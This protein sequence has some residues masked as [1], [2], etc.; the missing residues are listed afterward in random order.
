[1]KLK[2][3]LHRLKFGVVLIAAVVFSHHSPLAFAQSKLAPVPVNAITLSV[4][5]NPAKVKEKVTLTAQVKTGGKAATGGTVTF[6][7]GKLPLA[8]AQ[9]VGKKPAKGYKT[10][11][12][13][14]TTILAPGSHSLTAVYG[15]T[16]GSPKIVRSKRVALKITGRTAS[17][18]G[19][20]A[21]ANAHHPKN[22]DFTASVHGLGLAS[23][24]GMV[25]VTDITT[26]TDLGMAPLDAK[27]VSHSFAKARVIDA[28]GMPVQSV[29]AD[30]NGDG[31]PDVA[32]AN[33]AFG[34]RTALIGGKHGN[35]RKPVPYPARYFGS[36]IVA[37]DFNNDGILDL[38]IMSQGGSSGTEGD[39]NLY[40]GK[41]DGT[42]QT[43]VNY[44]LGGLPVAIALGDYNRDGIL[45]FATT[46]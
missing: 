5:P 43:A 26:G 31:F 12:A 3:S 44:A 39:V 34:P 1:M 6:F 42:F 11:N 14:A 25:D 27:S 45:D 30:F 13:I 32:T 38:A 18:T 40:L 7:D 46:D 4:S 21:K 19:L 17:T 2:V 28:A 35:F 20:T 36:G 9:V 23:P 24:Q 37:G 33:A 16:A 15:G 22:Y 41:G 10:G 8:S 29:V